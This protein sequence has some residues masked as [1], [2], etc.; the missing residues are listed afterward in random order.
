MSDLL[1]RAARDLI[2]RP[3]DGPTADDLH[4]R[5]IARRHRR[6]A[7]MAAVLLVLAGAGLV[8][9]TRRDTGGPA[10][11]A[12]VLTCDDGGCHG[13]DR[14]PVLDGA[15]DYYVGPASLGSPSVDSRFIEQTLRCV[16][17]NATFDG[18]TKVE[19][20]A[21][22]A[23]VSYDD[24]SSGTT[25][26][27]TN[28]PES[29]YWVSIGT[30][31]VDSSIED[32]ARELATP[33]TSAVA[34]TL[35]DG[36]PALTMDVSM[37]PAIMW[38]AR[39]GVVAWV[40]VPPERAGELAAIA[41]GVRRVAGPATI[42][43][44]VVVPGTGPAFAGGSNN[45]AGLLV[46]RLGGDECVGLGY[47]DGCGQDIAARTFVRSAV[48]GVAVTGAV[49]PQVSTVR[50]T[51]QFGQPQVIEPLPF[52]DYQSRFFAVDLSQDAVVRVEWLD[53]DGTVLAAEDQVQGQ[54]YAVTSGGGAPIALLR[55]DGRLV[56]VGADVTTLAAATPTDQPGR[57]VG[58]GDAPGDYLCVYVGTT[59][60]MAVTCSTPPQ[61]DLVDSSGGF[62]YGAVG[63]DV[64]SVEVDG[65][66]VELHALAEIPDRRFF[67][68]VG[69]S[70][71]LRDAAG[72]VVDVPAPVD[73]RPF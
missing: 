59:A 70:A 13:F 29:S 65:Q 57:Y 1:E 54:Q 18:C 20:M 9:V 11:G 63:A 21:I 50:V 48:D 36:R 64:A 32:Y 55:L 66:P 12:D 23:A 10:D 17:L 5:L 6:V 46:G 45:G 73:R 3:T 42:A 7:T 41:V 31:F 56:A 19:G 15:A 52:A 53:A 62:V 28:R 25:V 35:S 47:V 51:P 67:V 71:V 49:P 27:T 60:A 14:L 39:P 58:V 69:A 33:G 68:A 8:A 26:D 38:Q 24:V 16:E 43:D 30:T 61:L 22:V 34:A 40:T 44:R 4:R 2:A 72:N 37:S